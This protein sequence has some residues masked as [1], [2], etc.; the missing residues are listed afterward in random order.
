MALD[1]AA[2]RVLPVGDEETAG[3]LGMHG[4][5]TV[6]VDGLD[7]EERMRAAQPFLHG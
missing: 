4:S 3:S 7:V 1:T 5:P 6:T 2:V